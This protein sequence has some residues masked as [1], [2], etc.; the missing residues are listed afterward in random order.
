MFEFDL[1][2]RLP[3]PVIRIVVHGI[4]L[5]FVYDSTVYCC[6]IILAALDLLEK[7]ERKTGCFLKIKQGTEEMPADFFKAQY[8][9]E[10]CLRRKKLLKNGKK[11]T[12][13]RLVV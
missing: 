11:P 5:L 6:F 4:I 3:V 2:C 12:V 8:S 13:L 7:P 10:G 9:C 1:P